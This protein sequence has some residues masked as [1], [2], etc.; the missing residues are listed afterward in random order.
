MQHD[1]TTTGTLLVD[2][3]IALHLI[4]FVLLC[5]LFQDFDK[6]LSLH[7]DFRLLSGEFEL[8][9]LVL[10]WN[11]PCRMEVKTSVLRNLRRW[12]LHSLRLLFS[13][14]SPICHFRA[15]ELNFG[16][17]TQLRMTSAELRLL[18][19]EISWIPEPHMI[20]WERFRSHLIKEG[21]SWLLIEVR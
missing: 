20:T 12:F 6:F 11:V 19:T 14:L 5:L 1:R 9:W 8:D 16:R 10:F 7:Q 2:L 3:H 21:D 18:M 13:S 17:R 4:I 15:S